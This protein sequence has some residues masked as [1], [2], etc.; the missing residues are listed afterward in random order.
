MTFFKECHWN[1]RV[2][3]DT[4]HSI[5]REFQLSRRKKEKCN[6]TMFSLFSLWTSNEDSLIEEHFS[7]MTAIF[8]SILLRFVLFTLTISCIRKW[9]FVDC[10]VR[11][12]F[13]IK[14]SWTIISQNKRC[15]I[16]SG[17]FFIEIV[18][19]WREI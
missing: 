11:E 6:D 13:S 12:T 19:Y 5:C 8:E 3:I 18:R 9:N 2:N 15:Q 14:C 1:F 4:H 10:E 17:T 7:T 16:F